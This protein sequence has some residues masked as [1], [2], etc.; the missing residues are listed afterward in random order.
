MSPTVRRLAARVRSSLP[1]LALLLILAEG[2]RLVPGGALAAIVVLVG[3][4]LLDRVRPPEAPLR[5]VESPVRGPW[6][7]LNSPAT[8]TPSHGTNGLGQTYA[9]D[10]VLDPPDGSR[11]GFGSGG[12]WRRP[13]EYPA[14]GQPL[15]SP[16]DGVVVRVH[17]RQRDHRA[18]S[19]WLSVLY[20]LGPEGLV[21]MFGG[22]RVI[23]GNHVVVRADDGVHAALGH[24]RRGSVLV[25]L[26]E[27]VVAGQQLA[28]CGNSGNS[29][30]PHLHV[31]LCDSA[32]VAGA[33]GIPMAFRAG[34][35]DGADGLPADGE[36]LEPAAG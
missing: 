7:A 10:L 26:G 16:V 20:L 21:R 35:T 9:I 27:R 32:G 5:V 33:A 2:T 1:A 3:L 4:S 34:G 14:F 29:S 11:P 31:Q 24:L 8:K 23:F 19:G 15:F 18:R 30:E 28:E 12:Q 22:T 25:R 17:Q 36:L 6:R 13:E